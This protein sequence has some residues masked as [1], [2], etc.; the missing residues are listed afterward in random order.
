MPINPDKVQ[1]PSEI[2]EVMGIVVN[3]SDRTLSIPRVKM[4]DIEEVVENF[5][6]KTY[7]TKGTCNHF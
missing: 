7:M 3:V 6:H 4:G 1:P 5:S 2:M